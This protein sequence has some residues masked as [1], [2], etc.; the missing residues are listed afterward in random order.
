VSSR[1]TEGNL[2]E[3]DVPP[4]EVSSDTLIVVNSV[5]VPAKTETAVAASEGIPPDGVVESDNISPPSL[6]RS[7]TCC[8]DEQEE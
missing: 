3:E 6:I 8:H 5:E 1:Y 2:D 4:D 7:Y